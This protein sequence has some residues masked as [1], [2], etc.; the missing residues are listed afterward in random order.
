MHQIQAEQLGLQQYVPALQCVLHVKSLALQF[1]GLTSGDVLRGEI[2]T[3]GHY[4]LG[5]GY[6]VVAAGEEGAVGHGDVL[7]EVVLGLDLEP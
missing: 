7:L 2:K 3:H 6:S 1:A 5:A 4:Q